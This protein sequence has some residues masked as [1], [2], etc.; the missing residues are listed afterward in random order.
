MALVS[1]VCVLAT[2]R[3]R[4]FAVGTV[5]GF[6]V[7]AFAVGAVLGDNSTAGRERGVPPVAARWSEA[8]SHLSPGALVG[9]RVI[10]G[11]EG[12]RVPS[13]LRG[14]IGAGRLAGVVL[15]ADNFPSRAAGR[16]LIRSLQAIPR[17]AGLRDP[18]LILADQEGG[19]VKRIDGAPALPAREMSARGPSFSSAQG[20]RTAAN[21]RNVGINVDLAP[22]LD[23]ARPGSAITETAREWGYSASE[24]E[25][26]AIP[27]AIG[28]QD[29]GVAAVAKH[30]PGIGAARGNTDAGVQ[31]IDVSREMLRR[32]DEAPFRSFAATGGELVMLGAAIYPAFSSRPALFSR[33][34]V[35]GELRGRVG[36]NGVVLT[37]A[38]DTV[39]ALSLGGPVEAG[40]AAYQA[41]ADLLLY[42]EVAPALAAQRALV[43]RL[44]S[45]AA[46]RAAFERSVG[47]V[48]RLRNRL[49]AD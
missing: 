43:R 29:G 16:R 35:A 47:R 36:F 26:G 24:V 33:S 41:G 40:L 49:A 19:L 21:L 15:F 37:D 45:D 27:F 30:F 44:R 32:V 8:A 34:I 22:V 28:L 6:A 38:L 46:D 11:L 14:A 17:P 39:S 20:E 10:A 18:L 2:I 4:R 23:V 1:F 5:C 31:R 7:A 48:L 25:A 3:R 12:T 13:S 9:Q 42:T